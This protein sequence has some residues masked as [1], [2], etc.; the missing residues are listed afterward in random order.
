VSRRSAA[1]DPEVESREGW[2]KKEVRKKS[3]VRMRIQRL[4]KENGRLAGTSF[5]TSEFWFL[6][7]DFLVG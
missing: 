4:E 7:S 3:E 6:T 5:L 2:R 1:K